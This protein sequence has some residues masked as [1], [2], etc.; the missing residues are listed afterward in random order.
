MEICS[1]CVWGAEGV[2]AGGPGTV[3]T[4]RQQTGGRGS[5]S[6]PEAVFTRGTNMSSE[7]VEAILDAIL[8]LSSEERAE[9]ARDLPHVLRAGGQTGV[10]ALEAV[11]QVV[12]VRER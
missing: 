3:H 12:Q 7:R 1:T 11:R 8:Q 5:P 9:L 4:D 10:L 2:Y 6:S